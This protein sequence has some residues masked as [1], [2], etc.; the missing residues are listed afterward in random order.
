MGILVFLPDSNSEELTSE[1]GMEKKN[2]AAVI[3]ET[4]LAPSVPMT[5]TT[6]VLTVA[7][8]SRDRE[9]RWPLTFRIILTVWGFNEHAEE[10]REPSPSMV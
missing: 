2:C 10:T 4:S 1:K 3:S 6:L 8:T 5:V 7:L 9:M